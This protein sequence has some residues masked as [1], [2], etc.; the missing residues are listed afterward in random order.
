MS[1][2]SVLDVLSRVVENPVNLQILVTLSGSEMNTREIAHLLNKSEADIS[3]RM[4]LLRELG[5]VTYRWVRVGSK[6]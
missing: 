2:R 5:L 6:T 1:E 4:K 3:R